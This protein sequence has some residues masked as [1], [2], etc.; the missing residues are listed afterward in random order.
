MTTRKRRPRRLGKQLPKAK[1]VKK[2]TP[3][4]FTSERAR[5]V[6]AKT[7]FKPGRSGNPFGRPGDA[8]LPTT[9]GHLVSIRCSCGVVFERWIRVHEAARDLVSRRWL[10]LP[11]STALD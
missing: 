11:I 5:L 3:A 2:A 6:G 8:T 10:T 9:N 1:G 7:Q 4:S